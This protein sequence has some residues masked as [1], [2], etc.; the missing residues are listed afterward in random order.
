MLVFALLGIVGGTANGTDGEGELGESFHSGCAGEF[1]C[2]RPR[3]LLLAL[4]V[5]EDPPRPM[6]AGLAY[7]CGGSG[8]D[9]MAISGIRRWDGGFELGSG[10]PAVRAIASRCSRGGAADTAVCCCCCC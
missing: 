10:W 6:S 8:S 1:E 9:A 7:G 2:E 3:M 4:E 5:L